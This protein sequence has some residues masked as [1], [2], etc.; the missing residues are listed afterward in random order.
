MAPIIVSIEGAQISVVLLNVVAKHIL[1]NCKIF[2]FKII[3]KDI[4]VNVG[5][6]HA[7]Q[8]RS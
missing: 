8:H 3:D 6:V 5:V 1:T 2:L 7:E 4:Q